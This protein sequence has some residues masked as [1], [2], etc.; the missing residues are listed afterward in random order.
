MQ[1]TQDVIF[2]G[3]Q[4]NIYKWLAN[5][6]VLICTSD[7]EAF[8]MNL[9]EAFAC[10]TKVVSSNCQYG[11]NEILLGEYAKFLVKPDDIEGYIEKIKEAIEEYPQVQNPII[12]QCKPNNIINQYIAFME[13]K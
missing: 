11:P 9:I 6:E 4:D 3:W 5:C 12:E 10:K 2:M 1:L 8:P 13:Q 7:V